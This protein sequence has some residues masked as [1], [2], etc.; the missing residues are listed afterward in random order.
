MSTEELIKESSRPSRLRQLLIGL[1]SQF[2]EGDSKEKTAPLI[3]TQSSIHPFKL[4]YEVDG[5]TERGAA[6]FF[7]KLLPGGRWFVGCALYGGHARMFCW[8]LHSRE[9]AIEIPVA[10]IDSHYGAIAILEEEIHIQPCDDYAHIAIL[11]PYKVP[12]PTRCGFLLHP[13]TA[14]VVQCADYILQS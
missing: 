1:R 8:D 11:L 10:H 12:G 3:I 5:S 7:T 4:S 9:N 14:D 13:I 6:P 2:Q